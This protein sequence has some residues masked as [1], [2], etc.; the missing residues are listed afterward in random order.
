MQNNLKAL[1]K[2]RGYSVSEFAR[3]TN[4]PQ[5]TMSRIVSGP[6]NIDGITAINFLRIAHGLGL[7]AEEFY[8]GDASFDRDKS[9]V[10]RVFATTTYEGRKAMLANALGVES[11]YASYD[12]H[13][14]PTIRDDMSALKGL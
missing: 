5:P 2:A 12:A 1:L 9:T 10:D 11:A 8:Y 3:L 7:T 6:V 13:Y 4:I 14:L